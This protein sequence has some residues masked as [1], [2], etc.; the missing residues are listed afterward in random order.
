MTYVTTINIVL[1]TFGS[2]GQRL[3]ISAQYLLS[4]F[5]RKRILIYWDDSEPN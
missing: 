2:L 4:L 3:L 1:Y 5:P